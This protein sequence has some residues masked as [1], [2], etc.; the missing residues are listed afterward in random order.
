MRYT[1]EQAQ[2]MADSLGVAVYFEK[3]KIVHRGEIIGWE[4][5]EPRIGA[6]PI[7]GHGNDPV[8]SE[9]KTG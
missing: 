4:R 9:E 7:M 6:T 1:R 8:S 5:M 3:G 2:A